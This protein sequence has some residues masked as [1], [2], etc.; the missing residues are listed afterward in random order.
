[1]LRQASLLIIIIITLLLM[2]LMF[3]TGAEHTAGCHP[4]CYRNDFYRFIARRKNM[5]G[6]LA[7]QRWNIRFAFI[8][9]MY[10]RNVFNFFRQSLECLLISYE[11]VYCSIYDLLYYSFSGTCLSSGTGKQPKTESGTGACKGCVSIVRML[12]KQ[13]SYRICPTISEPR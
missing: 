6:F 13:N 8:L 7:L 12:P 3:F 11:H 4:V 9:L 5:L 10:L 2:P 1:M